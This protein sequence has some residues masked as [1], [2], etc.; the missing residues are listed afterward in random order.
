M[1]KKSRDYPLSE[2]PS[3]SMGGAGSKNRYGV[4]ASVNVPVSK[5]LSVGTDAYLGRD[6]YGKS[7]TVS[8]NATL[9][10]PIGRKRKKYGK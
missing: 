4:G 10:L 7:N 5:K 1:A 8:Y 3:I 9:T 6:E 2:S